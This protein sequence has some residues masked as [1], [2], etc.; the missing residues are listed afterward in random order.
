[1]ENLGKF[2]IGLTVYYHDTDCYGVVWHGAYVKWLEAART[3]YCKRLGVN[4][5]EFY[6]NDIVMPLSNINIDYKCPAKLEDELIVETQIEKLTKTKVIF[7]QEI[8]NPKTERLIISAQVTVV[9]TTKD[10]RLYRTM[11]ELLMNYLKTPINEP[12][13]TLIRC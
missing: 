11:P 13:G 6:D 3:E 12:E 2:R 9:T 7:R 1:M 4:F 10:G 5:S 8:F